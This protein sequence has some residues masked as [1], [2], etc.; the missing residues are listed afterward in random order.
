[1]CRLKFKPHASRHFLVLTT[2][3]LKQLGPRPR[4][5]AHGDVGLL[6]RVTR[7][8]PHP[9]PQ[10]LAEQGELPKAD[11]TLLFEARVLVVF[12][13]T[14][15][16]SGGLCECI[17]QPC[18]HPPIAEVSLLALL[19]RILNS[20]PHAPHAPADPPSLAARLSM[21]LG[22]RILEGSRN[23]P[24]QPLLLH[25]P[26]SQSASDALASL[27][28]VLA[29]SRPSAASEVAAALNAVHTG[30]AFSELIVPPSSALVPVSAI[31]EVWHPPPPLHPAASL[32]TPFPSTRRLPVPPTTQPPNHPVRL[33]SPHTPIAS[34]TPAQS[35]AVAA[36]ALEESPHLSAPPS[37]AMLESVSELSFQSMLRE[38]QQTHM[39]PPL[40]VSYQ[41]SPYLLRPEAGGLPF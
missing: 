38:L 26:S 40:A 9:V 17:I 3:A 32:L 12:H 31:L 22:V 34:L 30:G 20:S 21:Q 8:V 35:Q 10:R 16:G 29:A 1:M 25:A 36:E 13:W 14:E 39:V 6:A 7:Y 2:P 23:I 33:H 19:H 4:R 28:S 18:P 11:I 41:P 24:S 37:P 27:A 5:P 15:Q